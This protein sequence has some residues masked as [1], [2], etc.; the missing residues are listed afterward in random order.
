LRTE[1]CHCRSGLGLEAQR[2]AVDDYLNGG[3]WTLVKEFVEI[4]SGRR[5]DRPELAKALMLCRAHR[6]ALVVAKVDRLTRSHD[7][8]TRLNDSRV[9]VRF[10]DLPQLEGPT[11]RFLLQQMVS[12]A[13]LEA[14]MIG[15]RTRRE[16]GARSST[17]PTYS[18]SSTGWIPIA[19]HRYARWRRN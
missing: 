17:R 1:P 7:F 11:G 2:K 18:P 3:K 16:R 13:E 4:E 8:L 19:Q 15:D 6:A 5:A 10:C 12:V 9:E 14:G